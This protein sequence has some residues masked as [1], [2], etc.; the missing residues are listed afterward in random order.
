MIDYGREQTLLDAARSGETEVKRLYEEAL[1]GSLCRGAAEVLRRQHA[2]L[3]W[4]CDR[5]QLQR[6]RSK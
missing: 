4:L 5:L 1:R 2:T 6:D 3:T